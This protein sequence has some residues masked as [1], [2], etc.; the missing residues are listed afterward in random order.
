MVEIVLKSEGSVRSKITKEKLNPK[1]P[2]A[3]LFEFALNDPS[4]NG[5]IDVEF[6]AQEISE[7][8]L[9]NV[10]TSLITDPKKYKPSMNI[11]NAFE[12]SK[13][14][15][16]L[17][18][19]AIKSLKLWKNKERCGKWETWLKEL[20]SFSALPNFF[21]LFM[22]DKDCIEL[23]FQVLSGAPDDSN[24]DNKKKWEDE[25]NK[26]VK[27]AYG[28]LAEVFA[29]DS[30][31]KIREYAIENDFFGRIL[32]RIHLISKENKRKYAE[33]VEDSDSEDDKDK[34]KG[35]S[36][37][38]KEE[39]EDYTKKVEK[40]KG[41]GYGSDYTGQNQ[42]WD[43]QQYVDSKKVRN[44]QLGGMIEILCNFIASKHW[45]PPK[46]VVHEICC[47]ALLPL[48]EAA[49]RSASLLEMAKEATLN[50]QYLKL[51]RVMATHKTLIPTLLDLDPHYQPAQKDSVYNL[52]KNLKEL[53]QIFLNC[54]TTAD[55]DSLANQKLAEDIL[56]TF[57][58]LD[59]AI[60]NS[61]DFEQTDEGEFLNILNQPLD[62]KYRTL[63]KD[64]RFDYVS[65]KDTSGKFKHH[66][67]S[68]ISSG[69]PPQ[70]KMIRLA[71]ELADMSTALPIEHTNSI[72][73]RVDDT[74]VDVMKALIMGASGTPYGHGAY[75]YDIYF[76]DSYPNGPPKVNLTTTGSGK[77]RFN[78]NL[79]SCG[80]VCLS[81][82]G[83]WRGNASENWDPKLSTLL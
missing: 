27:I 78:P 80:K 8:A 83:T 43:V 5:I 64:L 34:K 69:T 46:K 44:E 37:D 61:A 25:E 28:I 47:S 24:E 57:K 81:L 75:E 36:K 45:H 62:T 56:E 82:L 51:T 70:N 35:D 19:T 21:G 58:F 50:Q 52:L 17:I 2:I 26:A 3:T 16:K 48:I 14:V 68:N 22:K 55:K 73:V 40:K 71:Q 10:A 74:R 54:L 23:F 31:P 13:G 60:Q 77:V 1:T 67:A 39:E 65:I 33:N 4:T 11:F 30:D 18:N 79:Y 12:E 59:N 72:F 42:R 66:Y 6:D 76:D 20:S 32:E 38:K 41:I 53:A 9:T 29:V 15:D 63:L 49:F 7:K